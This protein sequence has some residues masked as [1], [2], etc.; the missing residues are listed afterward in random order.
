VSRSARCATGEAIAFGRQ[1]FGG[2]IQASRKPME[3]LL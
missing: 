1:R 3:I 2:T